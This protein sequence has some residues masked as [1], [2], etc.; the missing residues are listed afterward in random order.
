MSTLQCWLKRSRDQLRP[1]AARV[2]P[3][4]VIAVSPSSAFLDPTETSVYFKYGLWKKAH[5]HL[6]RVLALDPDN[7]EA[8]ALTIDVAPKTH[9]QREAD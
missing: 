3:V 5:A 9:G 1:I 2:L 7:R 8:Q 4:R 6:E